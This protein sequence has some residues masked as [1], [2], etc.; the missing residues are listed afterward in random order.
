MPNMADVCSWA[1]RADGAA[2][3]SSAVAF[4]DDIVAI[5]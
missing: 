3:A 4:G 1:A 5:E 2:S